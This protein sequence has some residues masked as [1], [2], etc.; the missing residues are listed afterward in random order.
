MTL[1]QSGYPLYLTASPTNTTLRGTVP[2][3]PTLSLQATSSMAALSAALRA[4]TGASARCQEIG[5]WRPCE[6]C[7][8]GLQL[9]AQRGR[10]D[11]ARPRQ[12]TLT[13]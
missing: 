11:L 1:F 4:V 10:A 3:S 12:R 5:E 9:R 2:M 13:S 8:P 7:R 6:G